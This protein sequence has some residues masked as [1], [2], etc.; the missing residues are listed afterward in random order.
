MWHFSYFQ[1]EVD[2]LLCTEQIHLLW[3]ESAVVFLTS[4]VPGIPESPLWPAAS[5]HTAELLLPWA[6]RPEWVTSAQFS[7]PTLGP[8]RSSPQLWSVTSRL[9]VHV[10]CCLVPL[11][12]L[13]SA[14]FES[15]YTLSPC[16]E[17]SVGVTVLNTLGLS[18]ATPVSCT[19][20]FST[21]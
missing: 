11:Y 17:A 7:L 16:L 3:F 18:T 9:S 2:L 12:P 13:E 5:L 15:L 21:A 6:N 20:S 14:F 8:F 1:I 19:T 4:T 10:F